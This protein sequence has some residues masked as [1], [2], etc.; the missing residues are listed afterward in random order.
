ML[1]SKNKAIWG[2]SEDRLCS[3]AADTQYGRLQAYFIDSEFRKE[4]ST[5]ALLE[6]L[7]VFINS[8]H[9]C[10][11]YLQDTEDSSSNTHFQSS[12]APG[13]YSL[14]L[15]SQRNFMS[16][17]SQIMA[18]FQQKCVTYVIALISVIC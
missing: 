10:P 5:S 3:D 6:A 9:G 1:T 11:S 13:R 16:L 8:N 15:A 14:F 12:N 2:T 7:L 4:I 17:L 18:V